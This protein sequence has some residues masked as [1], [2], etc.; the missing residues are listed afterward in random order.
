M[1]KTVLSVVCLLLIVFAV[2]SCGKKT[3]WETGEYFEV[4][5][6]GSTEKKEFHYQ[7]FDTQHKTIDS[8]STGDTE[9]V[10][11]VNDGFL[12]LSLNHGSDATEYK[13]YDVS[14]GLVSETYDTLLSDRFTKDG[15]LVACLIHEDDAVAV[16][17]QD[18]FDQKVFYKT[19]Q[20][21]FPIKFSPSTQAAFI[22]DD[23]IKIT[24]LTGE[25]NDE[26]TELFTIK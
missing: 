15:I 25:D 8:G 1:K 19:F 26:K 6:T 14:K 21:E 9:P 12:R 17:I 4:S 3:A 11:Y 2:G 24:Y 13:Y 16:A 10:F 23:Q 7:V 20:G 22:S 18:A 5:N